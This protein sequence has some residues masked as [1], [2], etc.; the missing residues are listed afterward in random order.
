MCPQRID[1]HDSPEAPKANSL[2][3]CVNVVVVNEAGE[4]LLIR[5][6]DN[7]NWPPPRGRR[8]RRVHRPGGGP[9]DASVLS[10]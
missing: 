8:S 9:R 3:P 6:A 1:Y 4:I 10:L 5:R 2:V 7:G